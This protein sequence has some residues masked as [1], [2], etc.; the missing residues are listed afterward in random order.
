MKRGVRLSPRLMAA[1]SFVPRGARL[2]DVGTDHGLVPAF[3]ALEGRCD[4]I[5]AS[6]IREGPLS[7]AV[8]T[9]EKSG[10]ADRIDFRLAD[11]L[12]GM[13][14]LSLD[15][16]LI[17]GMGG[18]TIAAMLE[19]APWTAEERVTLLLQPQSKLPEVSDLLSRL[20]KPVTD[21]ALARDAGRLYLVMK[22]SGSGDY[23]PTAAEKYAPRVLLD[24]R[25]ALLPDYLTWL[26]S[27]F[28]KAERAIRGAGREDAALTE[29]LRGL[30]AM[31]EE[32]D[33][34]RK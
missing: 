23:T 15:T 11:G 30:A 13:E 2:A 6:D 34:W 8:R 3:L 18:E 12:R 9:A 19:R 22:A 26:I 29:A 33:T 4:Y 25:D 17:A 27:R 24:K 5:V 16:L 10:V 31:K 21:A 32:T 14:T 20:R 28:S 7:A 1:A